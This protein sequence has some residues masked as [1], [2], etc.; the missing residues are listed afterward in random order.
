MWTLA[1]RN[2]FRHRL[3]SGLTLA[4]VIFGVTGLMLSGGFVRDIFFQLG[5]G[6]LH[7]QL[8]HVQIETKG[9]YDSGQSDPQRNMVDD[10]GTIVAKIRAVP[11]VAETMRR[12]NFSGLLNNGRTGLPISGEGVEADKEARLGSAMTVLEGRQ[13]NDNDVNGVMLG[14]GLARALDLHVGD[15][16]TLVVNTYDGALNTLDFRVVG[17]VRTMSRDFDARAVRIG[18]A[19]AQDVLQSDKIH[20]LVLRL[21]ETSATDTVLTAV[22]QMLPSERLEARPWG[23]RAGGERG[24][25]ARGRRR[26]GRRGG[27]G[28]SM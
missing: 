13:L 8:G 14:E 1:F 3:R 15:D 2:L 23:E 27:S 21:S 11:D 7:A 9:Y 26:G 16:A 19:A 6:A 12:V 18:L 28:R 25:G 17:I 20:Q 4:A 22:R 24:A 10:A 5:E